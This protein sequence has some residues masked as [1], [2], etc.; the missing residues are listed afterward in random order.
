MYITPE[1]YEEAE[2]NGISATA[3][4]RRVYQGWELQRAIDTPLRK[5]SRFSTTEMKPFIEMAEKNG[6][7][8]GTFRRRVKNSGYSPEQAATEPLM[9]LED[10]VKKPRP[11]KQI[12]FTP[13]QKAIMMRADILEVSARQRIHRFGWSVEDAISIPTFKTGV[14][15]KE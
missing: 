6:I 2:E 8:L 15:R 3:L 5:K 11:R 14:E 12:R 1:Q 4:Y 7:S 13:E 9:T 10:A